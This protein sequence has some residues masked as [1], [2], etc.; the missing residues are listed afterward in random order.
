MPA[1]DACQFRGSSFADRLGR[2]RAFSSTVGRR[3]RT[4]RY[5]HGSELS[6]TLGSDDRIPD[7]HLH[8]V[9][10]AAFD[11]E[12]VVRYAEPALHAA[13]G[14]DELDTVSAGRRDRLRLGSRKGLAPLG[15]KHIL[16]AIGVEGT[17]RRRRVQLGAEVDAYTA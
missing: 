7:T 3:E 1:G 8:A 17:R 12:T 15:A 13:S 2:F 11:Q 9:A 6:F 16:G 10:H 5:D 4:G 14:P